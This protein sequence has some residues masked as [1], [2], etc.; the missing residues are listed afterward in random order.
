MKKKKAGRKKQ[1]R[2]KE[3]TRTRGERIRSLRGDMTQVE[4]ADA[5]AIKQAMISRY[6]ADKETPSPKILLRM[7]QFYGTSIEW[8]LTGRDPTG[9]GKKKARPV[10]TK[11]MINAA[12]REIRQT[13]YPE[14]QEFI[15]MMKDVFRSRRRMKKILEYYRFLKH[16]G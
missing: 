16:E 7:A 14:A 3:E 1:S 4:S 15:E 10:S 12:A 13:H 8:I 5:V 2:P 9:A 11:D 6:E